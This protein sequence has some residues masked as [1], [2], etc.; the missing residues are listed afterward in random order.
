MEIE[1]L[2]KLSA[3][4]ALN[5]ISNGYTVGLGGG[6]SISYLIK[7]LSEREDI[8]IKV[9][10]PSMKTK[11]LCI[12]SGLEVLSTPFVEKVDI[13][14]DGCDQ[15][16]RS[17]NALKSGGA[18]HT[19]EK[20]IASMAKDYILLVDETKVVEKLQFKKP[21]AIEVLTEALGYVKKCLKEIGATV[22]IR[23]SSNKDGFLIS[24][25]GNVI[26][27]A[28]FSNVEDIALLNTKLNSITGIIATSLFVNK[29]TKVIIAKK[30]EIEI[31]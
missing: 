7:L 14:F 11:E 3:K 30:N 22:E 18:I 15:V 29:V 26:L 16:D 5:F 9:V 21:I 8:K 24:D 2:K 23:T 4:E 27:D 20:L 1:D 17:L 25:D 31:I 28:F 6:S 10:T 19:R 13:A 12:K